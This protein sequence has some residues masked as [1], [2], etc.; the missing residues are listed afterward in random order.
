MWKSNYL[1]LG[2]RIS[3]IKATLSNLLVYYMSL[4]GMP[5]VVREGLDC[6]R[7]IVLCEMKSS[8]GKLHFMR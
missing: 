6:I 4:F 5:A 8:T 7:R 1:Y 3:H 2:G